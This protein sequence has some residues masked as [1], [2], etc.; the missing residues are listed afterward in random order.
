MSAC[1]Q[2]ASVAGRW[3]SGKKISNSEIRKL[4]ASLPFSESEK[5]T[6]E[7][8]QLF[9]LAA[10]P[11]RLLVAQRLLGQGNSFTLGSVH[12]PSLV[13]VTQQCIQLIQMWHWLLG[14][15]AYSFREQI[16]GADA[17]FRPAYRQTVDGVPEILAWL[18]EAHERLLAEALLEQENAQS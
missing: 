18:R 2:D 14:G 13:I 5:D 4:L 6:R 11:H 12:P 17:A 1:A 7:L 15:V 9:S 10:H 3:Q 16:A 8:Y